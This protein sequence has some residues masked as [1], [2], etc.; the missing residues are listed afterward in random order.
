MHAIGCKPAA[1]SYGRLFTFPLRVLLLLITLVVVVQEN[2]DA[3]SVR[4]YAADCVA[5]VAPWE[6]A[7]ATT[8]ASRE[9]SFATTVA[10]RKLSLATATTNARTTMDD[11]DAVKAVKAQFVS[12][13]ISQL[14]RLGVHQVQGK[15]PTKMIENILS[16]GWNA[17]EKWAEWLSQ[18]GQKST[19]ESHLGYREGYR[20]GYKDGQ[21]GGYDAALTRRDGPR[22][23]PAL[24]VESDTTFGSIT[25][26]ISGSPQP[27]PVLGIGLASSMTGLRQT[28]PQEAQTI[29]TSAVPSTGE[30]DMNTSA[31]SPAPRN[32][33][34]KVEVEE[35]VS[36]LNVDGKGSSRGEDKGCTT[37]HAKRADSLVQSVEKP[38]EAEDRSKRPTESVEAA[39]QPEKRLQKANYTLHVKQ[40]DTLTETAGEP[41]KSENHIKR[42][43]EAVESDEAPKSGIRPKKPREETRHES[44]KA[45]EGRRKRITASSLGNFMYSSEDD[46]DTKDL[47]LNTCADSLRNRPC[48]LGPNDQT[49]CSLFHLCPSY[50]KGRRCSYPNHHGNWLHMVPTCWS[51]LQKRDCFKP[52]SCAYGHDNSD[53]RLRRDASLN[54]HHFDDQARGRHTASSKQH[55]TPHRTTERS[56]PSRPAAD[57]VP[58]HY[59]SSRSSDSA[60]K[61]HLGPAPTR[62][63]ADCYLPRR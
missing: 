31:T 13:A 15:M 42:S 9:P 7:F 56:P 59:S 3:N 44:S 52:Y 23:L 49:N 6:L 60:R 36:P 20:D 43:R 10:S 21:H 50:F 45:T 58:S 62:L 25:T 4:G 53:V 55:P 24:S 40:A 61:E 17:G 57:R 19:G 28:A 8:A 1:Q 2:C 54:A 47:L 12:H 33:A 16:V 14:E 39:G 32:Q 18:E 48:Q 30:V 46:L 41:E 5:E 26:Q 38:E 63:A 11:E 51:V 27:A 35:N 34:I 29:A 22:G 37:T